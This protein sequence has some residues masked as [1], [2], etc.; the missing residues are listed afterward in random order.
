MHL[1]QPE[2]IFDFLTVAK[3]QN[4]KI[5]VYALSAKLLNWT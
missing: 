1:L 2:E 4:R 5:A 3:E